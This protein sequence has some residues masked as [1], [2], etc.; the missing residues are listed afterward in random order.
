M[1]CIFCELPV[2]QTFPEDRSGPLAPLPLKAMGPVGLPA[3]RT[4]A[5]VDRTDRP[6]ARRVL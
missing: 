2:L 1:S 6:M 4:V 5:E 3:Q